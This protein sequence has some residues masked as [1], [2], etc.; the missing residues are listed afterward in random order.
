MSLNGDLN[1]IERRILD[2]RKQLHEHNHL[3]YN[4]VEPSISDKE[5]DLLM[6]ELEELENKYPQFEDPLSPTKRPGGE[7]VDGFDK[8]V[9]SH[10]MLSLSNTYNS[11]EIEEWMT[12]VEKRLEDEEIKYV[13][14]LKYDG[15]AIS[16]IYE[17]GRLHK[18]LTRGD[19]V[20]GEDVTSNVKTIRTI[21]LVL[22]D[23]API[24]LEIRGEIFY[25][26]EDFNRLNAEREEAG[27][28]TFANPR[29]TA[30]GTLKMQDSKVVAS[31]KLD[32][33]MYSVM[34]SIGVDSHS[35]AVERAG[36]WGFKNP[37]SSE[38][39]IET[40]VDAKGVMSFI[41]FWDKERHNLPFSIDGVVI[42]V[43]KYDQQE[44]LG[45]TSKSPRWAISY[46]FE[47]ERVLTKLEK[48]TY[49]V[50]RTGAITPVANLVPVQLGGTTVKRASLHNAD[51]IA[52]LDLHNN[53]MVYVEKGGEII[54]KIVDVD[55]GS[56]KGS[57]D[58]FGIIQFPISC[59]KCS[60]TL[61]RKDGEAAHYCPNTDG[62][63]PQIYGRIIHFIGR[64][65]MNIDGL[66]S[67]TVVQLVEAGL[68]TDVC[69]LY[70]L[71]E[72]DLLPLERMADKSVMKLLNGLQYSKKVPF[73]RVLF[74]LGIRF[75]GETVA[76]KLAKSFGDMDLLMKANQEE[77]EAV[78]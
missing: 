31:R 73:E 75:V 47:T 22:K 16:L 56:R 59:P 13:M 23:G 54:P 43:D 5:F 37:K 8:V 18:A 78:D 76:K 67:E 28:P 61:V 60:A 66:G 55:K 50:G 3:Y 62:C 69:S 11:E 19:G 6:K 52:K 12:R 10:P 41:E 63:P 9:H 17:N 64:K 42:K 48:V 74:A 44:R 20:T 1:T 27:E 40:S 65:S 15:V 24:K 39:M 45:M 14:E 77:L 35:M 53:D 29:N 72:E 58:M 36:K 21:P 33:M 30:A 4:V 38:N 57:L 32:C 46:K 34:D 71:K 49:Q 26:F 25:P 7:P 70:D 68:I 51:Q 2:L